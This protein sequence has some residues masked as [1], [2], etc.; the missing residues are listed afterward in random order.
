MPYNNTKTKN[1]HWVT[2]L[3]IGLF[4]DI[5]ILIIMLMI[6]ISPFQKYDYDIYKAKKDPV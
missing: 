3:C 6:Y 4:R 5:I 2:S 1:V